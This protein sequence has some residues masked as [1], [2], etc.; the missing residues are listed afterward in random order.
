[1]AVSTVLSPSSPPT[2]TAPFKRQ[3]QAQTQARDT[4]NAEL[5]PILNVSRLLSRLEQNLLSPVA[6]LKSLRRSEYQ[7]MRVGGVRSSPPLLLLP[8][9]VM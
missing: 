5:L 8:L 6:D 2:A 1:M 7:R 4:D 3:I 9:I